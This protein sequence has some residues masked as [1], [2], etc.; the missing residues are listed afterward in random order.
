MNIFTRI[1]FSIIFIF[2]LSGCDSLYKK[3]DPEV[4]LH[5]CEKESDMNYKNRNVSKNAQ[6]LYLK[7]LKACN[8]KYEACIKKPTGKTCKNFSLRYLVQYSH[9]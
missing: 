2:Q 3:T 6:K 8:K 5:L 1:V 9:M 4:L 7:A